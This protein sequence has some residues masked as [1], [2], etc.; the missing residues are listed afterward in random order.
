MVVAAQIWRSAPTASGDSPA[1][2]NM[3]NYRLIR[4]ERRGNAWILGLDVDRIVDDPTTDEL[5]A[6]L[7]AFVIDADP[8]N[9]VVDLSRVQLVSSA[10]IAFFQHFFRAVSARQGQAAL[11]AA[12]PPVVE[13]FGMVGLGTIF[14]MFDDAAAAAAAFG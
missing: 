4:P 14:T 13:L 12:R 3:K 9:V 5:R 11:C 1:V 10:G 7:A 8:P 6:E 2:I